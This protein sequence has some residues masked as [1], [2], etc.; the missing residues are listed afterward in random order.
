MT[1][2][3][4]QL[5]AAISGALDA[6]LS[7]R[8]QPAEAQRYPRAWAKYVNEICPRLGLAPSA[9]RFRL[10]VARHEL[11]R[12]LAASAQGLALARREHSAALLAALDR[13]T[14][15]ALERKRRLVPQGPIRL[16]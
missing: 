16:L 4:N 14:E 8:S 15:A 9:D 7:R 10:A 5:Q 11:G 3:P 2:R 6:A 12:S 13:R 1:T